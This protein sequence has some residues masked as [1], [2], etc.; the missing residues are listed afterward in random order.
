MS[1]W[2]R[3]KLVEMNNASPM[4]FKYRTLFF[5]GSHRLI[6]SCLRLSL[7]CCLPKVQGSAIYL[8]PNLL[9]PYALP[10]LAFQQ[11]TVLSHF[12]KMWHAI[13]HSKAAATKGKLLQYL[14]Q[15]ASSSSMS[16]VP[17]SQP[18]SGREVGWGLLL[19]ISIPNM[20]Y[21]HGGREN[22]R[23]CP[24]PVLAWCMAC[25]KC[26]LDVLFVPNTQWLL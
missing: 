8:Q 25:F 21:Q 18:W 15:C 23:F 12:C 24:S 11:H 6:Q 19:L 4:H 7:I 13:L 17:V 9:E 2:T 16:P 1:V 20:Q 22:D 10:E 26:Q 5:R 3:E 14:W